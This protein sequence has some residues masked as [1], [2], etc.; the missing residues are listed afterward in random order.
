M[1]MIYMLPAPEKALKIQTYSRAKFELIIKKN[2]WKG[3]GD[4]SHFI[5]YDKVTILSVKIK[6]KLKNKKPNKYN[7]LDDLIG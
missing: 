2:R 1:K 7:T 5:K 3:H 4:P 6:Y